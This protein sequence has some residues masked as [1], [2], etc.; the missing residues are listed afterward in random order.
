MLRFIVI[1]LPMFVTL[2][3]AISLVIDAGK[4]DKPRLFL[5][6]FMFVASVLYAS[7]AAFFSLDYSLYSIFDPI[8]TLT[9]LSVFPLFYL[10]I[11]GIAKDGTIKISGLWL[12]TPAIFFSLTTLISFI[13]MPPE[14]FYAYIHK[15][16]Y[17]ER[18]TF[19]FSII[20]QIQIILY[21]LSRIVFVLQL[22]PSVYYSTKLIK[23]YEKQ[24][25]EFYSS[26]EERTIGWTRD[27]MIAMVGVSVFA[28][29]ANIIGKAFF[30]N[31]IALITIPSLLF[32]VFHFAI[33]FLGFKQ[34]YTVATYKIDI[35]KD[36]S[37]GTKLPGEGMRQKLKADLVNLLE[38]EQ[39]FRHTDLRITDISKQLN[40]NRSYISGIVNNEFNSTFSDLINHYRIEFSKEL[41][42]DKKMY[43]LEYVSEES[44]FASINSFLRAF[45]K[46]TGITPGQYRKQNMN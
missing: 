22:I 13:L 30:V 1:T 41:L 5:G 33:G 36:I 20:G 3:W 37:P 40:T 16:I 38:N 7:H 28:V 32:S 15:V 42:K 19:S 43:I 35:S 10:Y 27:I 39:I 34:K 44:G 2:F 17:K 24:I 25:N 9:S 12:I 46:E 31:E 6:L 29:I 8:Y 18:V 45:K 14:E 4:K 11:K 21:R 23:V 26:T